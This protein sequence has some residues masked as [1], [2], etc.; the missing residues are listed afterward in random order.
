MVL[1]HKE[2][3][4]PERPTWY[5]Q[6]RSS[7][8]SRPVTAGPNSAAA[9]SVHAPLVL[10][11]SF[12]VAALARAESQDDESR[13]A[14]EDSSQVKHSRVSIACDPKLR[15]KAVVVVQDVL[16]CGSCLHFQQ[17]L[18]NNGLKTCSFPPRGSL[19]SE[20]ILKKLRKLKN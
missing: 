19:L 8:L 4:H 2:E 3:M 15:Q 6:L 20:G 16:E 9:P 12:P 11:A 13:E 14:V 17:L 5:V 7:A 10:S 1:K 18:T